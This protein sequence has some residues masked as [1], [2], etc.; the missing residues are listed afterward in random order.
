MTT[1]DPHDPAHAAI[2]TPARGI[3]RQSPPPAREDVEPTP[4]APT[5][6]PATTQI[7]VTAPD[8]SF[9]KRPLITV[10]LTYAATLIGA[11]IAS[12]SLS[13]ALP[14]DANIPDGISTKFPFLLTGM[15]LFGPLQGSGS[16]ASGLASASARATLA[17]LALTL[18]AL[19][20]AWLITWTRTP[21]AA[22]V[23]LRWRDAATTGAGL[24]V[25]AAVVAAIAKVS[26]DADFTIVSAAASV[27]VAPFEVLLGGFAIGTLGAALGFATTRS[28]FDLA[29]VGIRVPSPVARAVGNVT[30][31]A[32][33]AG[34][35]A[36]VVALIAGFVKV[37]LAAT[38]AAFFTILPNVLAY[39]FT[40]GAF[41]GI[42][43]SGELTDGDSTTLTLFTDGMPASA[44][45]LVALVVLAVLV[46]SV[47]GLLA[48]GQ[49]PW[50]N[51]WVTPA[52]LAGA[53]LITVLVTRISVS[54]GA[55]A[56]F[57][58]TSGSATVQITWVIVVIA[59]AWGLL[60]EVCERTIAPYV[61]A[62]IPAIPALYARVAKHDPAVSGVTVPAMP[63]VDRRKATIIGGAV[64]G[65][66]LLIGLGVI[67]RTVISNVVFSPDKPV[68]QYVQAL[69]AGDVTGAFAVADPDL[70]NAE[71]TLMTNAVY[72]KVDNR[73]AGGHV[74]K[75]EKSGDV[76]YVAVQS[77]QD[78]SSIT[79]QFNVTKSGHSF[80]IFDKWVLDAPPVPQVDISRIVP[81]DSDD[82]LVNGQQVTHSGD[83]TRV[84]PGTYTLSLPV[85]DDLKGAVT[86]RET[87][88][89]VRPDGEFASEI[90]DADFLSYSLT[91]DAKAQATAD[92]QAYLDEEC[93]PATM[94]SVSACSMYVSEYE[95]TN[96][97]WADKG[98][99]QVEAQLAPGG[100]V[101]TQTQGTATA[102]YDVPEDYFSA[103]RT[104]VTEDSTY[105]FWLD[106]RIEAG[107]LVRTGES[108]SGF[109]GE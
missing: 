11:V 74:T 22:T 72:S 83:I 71:R 40:L 21:A 16:A 92:A 94:L 23:T 42:H 85:G 73:P 51:L 69:E 65:V 10:A 57:T 33:V 87:T 24:G 84:L 17:P 63:A 9:L 44:Y 101:T 2:Q 26:W 77:K 90:T 48:S 75:V 106:Y 27:G 1:V 20:A 96:V 25:L 32:A 109:W 105:E 108:D 54:G 68:M 49:R 86:S 59:A 88:L 8:L 13:G 5:T 39:A 31:G 78:G 98:E 34:A 53:A 82:F 102:T 56:T 55:D 43:A 100:V 28:G 61:I 35:I 95:A 66:A 81:N 38:I 62:A 6:S 70:P 103:A 99:P 3:P 52:V 15:A 46:A 93:L 58:G 67:A 12:V 79:Q 18:I 97:S 4:P 76:A 14:D 64:V 29:R 80:L 7:V 91:D 107:K 37:G 50:T 36:T 41:G 47:R 104:G 19:A 60:I 89:T 30:T 45:L